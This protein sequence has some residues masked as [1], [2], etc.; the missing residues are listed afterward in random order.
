M[1]TMVMRSEAYS[2]WW[3]SSMTSTVPK[4]RRAS[5]RKGAWAARCVA[6]PRRHDEPRAR[7]CPR[8]LHTWGTSWGNTV[9]SEAITS[10]K[11]SGKAAARSVLHQSSSRTS[12]L[13][14]ARLVAAAASRCGTSRPISVSVTR[15]SG[16]SLC[17]TMP[18]RPQPAPTSSTCTPPPPAPSAGSGSPSRGARASTSRARATYTE[19][20]HTRVPSSEKDSRMVMVC[21]G[22]VPVV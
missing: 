14:L 7:K 19:V 18:S 6:H 16:L 4:R 13:L 11:L 2:G 20:S 21:D 17:R 9:M 15:H 3:R 8:T 10:W 22:L 5:S 12:R 1:R